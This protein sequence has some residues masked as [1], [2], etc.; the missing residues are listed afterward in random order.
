MKYLHVTGLIIFL[1]FSTTKLLAQ[2]VINAGFVAG[3]MSTCNGSESEGQEIQF[4]TISAS[5]LTDNITAKISPG[6][7][8]SLDEYTGF[9]GSITIPQSNGLVSTTVYVRLTGGYGPGVVSGSAVLT[10]GAATKSVTVTGTVRAL[11]TVIKP[12]DQ[13]VLNGDTTLPVYFTGTG[14][15]YTWINDTPSIGL[16][17]SGADSIH[18]FTAV[19]NGA[20]PVTATITVTPRLAGM[21]YITLFDTSNIAEIN[22]IINNVSTIIK[23]GG[24][25]PTAISLSP[26]YSDLY[27]VNSGINFSPGDV[28]KISTTT[29]TILNSYRVSYGDEIVVSPDGSHVYIAG[30]NGIVSVINTISNNVEAK[31]PLGGCCT[32][33]LSISPVGDL[34]YV[35]ELGGKI[36][37]IST[38]SNT[39]VNTISLS[40]GPGQLQISPDGSRLYV[41]NQSLV[42]D[43]NSINT[44]YVINTANKEVI[45]TLNIGNYPTNMALSPDG[46]TLYITSALTGTQL[47]N[48]ELYVINT[49]NNSV[50]KIIKVGA[51]PAGVSIS[52]DGGRV[53]VAN[54]A[55]EKPGAGTVTVINTADNTVLATVPVG[56]QPV[57]R[58]SFVTFG[59]CEGTPVTFTITV[60]P[61]PLPTVTTVNNLTAL[62]T[63]YGTAS[64]SSNFTISGTHLRA[65]ILITPPKGFEVSTDNTNFSKTVT[66]GTAGDVSSVLLYIRLAAT[67]PVGSY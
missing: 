21:A 49:T 30:N 23:S 6:F 15:Y 60:N 16:A 45:S 55:G 64:S 56:T 50:V 59:G 27:V 35:S 18:S 51:E 4:F 19:N 47:I 53:Y 33:G 48:D 31:I 22:T 1:F 54:S 13:I 32:E 25:G 29:N 67:T 5:G 7:E 14:N 62:N 61:A 44:L 10:S 65:G 34:L 2:A 42:T 17:A 12:G 52:P 40:A 39:I 41:V 66:V 26:D 11:P 58:G 28:V 36:F 8:L 20:T 24:T 46:K 43:V 57:S 3:H 38:T 9:S 37:V 63:I